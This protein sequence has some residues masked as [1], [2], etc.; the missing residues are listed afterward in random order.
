MTLRF[1]KKQYG[2]KM[3]VRDHKFMKY[4][5]NRKCITEFMSFFKNKVKI[6]SKHY[7]LYLIKM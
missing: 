4:S 1:K 5:K 2:N 3:F 7:S 6:I